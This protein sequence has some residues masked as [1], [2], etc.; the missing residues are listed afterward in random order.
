[1]EMQNDDEDLFRAD[2][3]STFSQLALQKMSYEEMT[4][5]EWEQEE[6]EAYQAA[7]D[8]YLYR[9]Q[10]LLRIFSKH[11]NAARLAGFPEWFIN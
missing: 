1:M 2:P 6:E 3:M 11:R 8:H 10:T 5:R 7:E 4:V 9:Q